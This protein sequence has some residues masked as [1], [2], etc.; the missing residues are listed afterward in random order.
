[1]STVRILV[2]SNTWYCLVAYLAPDYV[3]LLGTRLQGATAGA[4]R[5]PE[6][7]DGSME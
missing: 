2:G 4:R 5:L 6:S 1:M 7:A 3:L